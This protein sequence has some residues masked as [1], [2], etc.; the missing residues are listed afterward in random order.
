MFSYW[1]SLSLRCW[2]ANCFLVAGN[3]WWD[4]W[5]RSWS[6]TESLPVSNPPPVAMVTA[7]TRMH[8]SGMRTT[9]SSSHPRGLHQ[10]PPRA[11]PP[12]RHAG[13][14]PA[15]HTGIAHTPARHAGIPPAMHAR[16][17]HPNKA[18]WDTT[19]N[20]CWDSTPPPR[21]QNDK[22]V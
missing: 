4:T 10:A 7:Q 5:L 3:T 17:P 13:I 8:S 16:I 18:C 11:D 19:C 2:I 22:Q 21:E 9:R 1:L 20:A 12:A 14:P 6:L 15:M